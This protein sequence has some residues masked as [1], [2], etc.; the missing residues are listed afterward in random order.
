MKITVDFGM[1]ADSFRKADRKES[2][3]YCG[4]KALFD[5]LEEWEEDTGEEIELDPIG[6]CCEF[7]EY[8]TEEEVVEAYSMGVESLRDK[9]DVIEFEEGFIVREF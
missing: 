5:Y 6:F 2:F 7:A 8:S 1:F 3:S 9:T 4:L